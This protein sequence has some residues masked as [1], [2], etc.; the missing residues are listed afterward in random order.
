MA[1]IQTQIGK[2][3]VVLNGLLSLLI[4]AALAEHQQWKTRVVRMAEDFKL[5]IFIAISDLFSY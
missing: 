4:N 5:M 2:S 1:V 3:N